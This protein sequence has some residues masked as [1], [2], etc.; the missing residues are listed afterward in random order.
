MCN[1][2]EARVGHVT[3]G[4]VAFPNPDNFD[5]IVKDTS[6]TVVVKLVTFAV[7]LSLAIIFP[8]I[9]SHF[10]PTMWFVITAL[11]SIV[12]LSSTCFFVD[13]LR[14]VGVLAKT[15]QGLCMILTNYFFNFW[16]WLNPQISLREKGSTAKWDS[17]PKGSFVLA[18][19]CSQF[20]VIL[21]GAIINPPS[22]AFNVKIYYQKSLSKIPIFGLMF[23]WW[24]HFPVYFIND[25]QANRS[26]DKDK[27]EEVTALVDKFVSTKQGY[28]CVLPEGGINHEPTT[29]QPFRHGGFAPAIKYKVPLFALVHVGLSTMWPKTAKIGGNRARITWRLVK[30][31]VDYNDSGL[32]AAALA[33]S[34]QAQIQKHLDLLWKAETTGGDHD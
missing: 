19:H 12:P 8:R 23:K 16:I 24:G 2:L 25:K 18:K 6:A 34:C 22:V 30:I 10:A 21:F 29:L 33:D 14:Y 4:E 7:G 27:Q 9:A 17:L 20:D 13:K 11:V 5:P 3:P 1:V 15:T 26:V 31:N 32:T 28:L